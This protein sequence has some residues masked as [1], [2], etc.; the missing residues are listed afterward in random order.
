METSFG[1][2]ILAILR[3]QTDKLPDHFLG[4]SFGTLILAILRG[5]TDKLPDHFLGL[6]LRI[7]SLGEL[8]RWVW[9]SVTTLSKIGFAYCVHNVMVPAAT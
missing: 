7:Q 8:W 1:T 5:Q 6:D 4:T 2:L 3:G 9:I